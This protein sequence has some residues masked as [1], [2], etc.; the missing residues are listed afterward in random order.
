MQTVLSVAGLVVGLGA[1]VMPPL[2]DSE[3]WRRSIGTESPIMYLDDPLV[4]LVMT[5]VGLCLVILALHR[6]VV[7]PAQKQHA[8]E[9]SAIRA[10]LTSSRGVRADSRPS[11]VVVNN[12][13]Y[14]GNDVTP[15]RNPDHSSV[16]SGSMH[17]QQE[18]KL[19]AESLRESR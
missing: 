9:L 3:A 1:L 7:S 4:R 17:G 11:S 8:D 13:Y 15:L 18:V 10:Q 2:W 12:Y 19:G 6:L 14:Y 16:F 5:V